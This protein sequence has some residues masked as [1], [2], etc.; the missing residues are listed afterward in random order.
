M[1]SRI[2]LT[3]TQIKRL[4]LLVVIP[5]G[6]LLAGFALYLHGGRFVETDNAYVKADVIPI[7]AEV[8]GPI[9]KVLVAENQQVAKGDVLFKLDPDP[10]KVAVS[11]AEAKLAQVR[12]ELQAL[13]NS[14]QEKQAQ[15]EMA[16]S[17]QAFAQR[18][19]Q[20]Q[21]DLKGK[22]F[23]SVSELDDLEHRVEN[24]AQRLKVLRLDL[25]RIAVSLGGDVD[26]PL[27]EHPSYRAALADLHQAQLDLK[28]ATVRA[29]AAGVASKTPN[30][31]QYVHA[32]NTVLA[33]V[34]SSDLWIEANFTETD[35]THVRPGQS[36]DIKIDTYPGRQWQGTVD[37]LSPATGAE[38]SVIPPQNAT[39]N[40]VK[41]AQRV[42]VRIH[43][44][45][46]ADAPQLRAGLSA[47]V[48]I[49]TQYER[50]LTGLFR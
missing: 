7:S 5:A 13:K 12:T 48:E 21:I 49:D 31:G 28:R 41:I 36:V 16:E 23:V 37:S 27:E 43:V 1:A 20:R 2:P 24:S 9:I 35:L 45:M 17:D 19:L 30:V 11:R 4:I 34:G 6:F 44:D 15:I 22:N 46:P 47:V 18:E 26:A 10:F 25:Q 40:W 8:S 50:T 29:P 42:P 32:G 38:F 14:Y 33:L 39:G 3:A